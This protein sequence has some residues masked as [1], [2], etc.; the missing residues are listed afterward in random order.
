[1]TGEGVAKIAD[2][3][4]AK[5]IVDNGDLQSSE[6]NAGTFAYAAPELILGSRCTHKVR[7]CDV[8]SRGRQDVNWLET[9]EIYI[10]SILWRYISVPGGKHVGIEGEL[11]SGQFAKHCWK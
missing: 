5:F 10:T 2:V 11:N 7:A 9:A 3:G 4:L 6:L 8:S 1:M